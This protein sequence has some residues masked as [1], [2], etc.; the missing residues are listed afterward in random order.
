MKKPEFKEIVIDKIRE[1]YAF[2][3]QGELYVDDYIK[4]AEEA[5]DNLIKTFTQNIIEIPRI[6]IHP[7]E[8]V[9]CGFKDFDLDVRSLNYQPVSEEIHRQNLRDGERDAISGIGVG[10]VPDKLDNLIVNEL[11]NYP[12]VDYDRDAKFLF[13]LA[14]QAIVKFKANGLSD[15]D[16]DNVIQNK[17]REL[18]S[19]IYAQLM[20][21]FEYEPPTF[22]EIE[23]LPFEAIV[24][25]NNEK[26]KSDAVEHYTTTIDPTSDIPKKLFMGFKKSCH[27][28]YKFGSKTEKDFATILENDKAVLKWLRP[29]PKQ[30][31]IY[32][33]HNSREYEPDF[34]VESKDCIYLVKTKMRKDI[35]GLE[36]QSKA[37]AALQYCQNATRFTTQN[38]GKPW[39]YVLIPHDA[40]LLNASFDAL[41]AKYEY[42][43]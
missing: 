32:W 9:R 19:Y 28:R 40:V 15:D 6:T 25:H 27:D 35:G 1:K 12:E 10:I 16:I 37:R 30:F 2:A 26:I 14:N 11:I 31:K 24:Q 34:V 29:A 33:E 36:V 20:D 7:K 23:V 8:D 4:V 13:K 18:G 41:M 22:E 21:N 43:E 38:G 3:K 42:H 17:K 39:K 5:Y